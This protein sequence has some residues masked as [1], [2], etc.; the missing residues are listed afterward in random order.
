MGFWA[1]AFAISALLASWVRILSCLLLIDVRSLLAV[2]VSS[3]ICCLRVLD[4]VCIFSSL[5][6]LL[7]FSS[8]FVFFRKN[9]KSIR[10]SRRE[11]KSVK[12][13]EF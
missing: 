13:A 1:V 6:C 5:F 3:R 9:V 8:P 7:I 4:S 10:A 2:L 11:L 12:E